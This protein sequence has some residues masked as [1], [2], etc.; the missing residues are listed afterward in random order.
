M[1]PGSNLVSA[2]LPNLREM[3]FFLFTI[4]HLRFTSCVLDHNGFGRVK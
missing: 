1:G 2:S 4:Y 3:S